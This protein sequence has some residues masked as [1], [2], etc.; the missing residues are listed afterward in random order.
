[1]CERE[2]YSYSQFCWDIYTYEYGE[3]LNKCNLYITLAEKRTKAIVIYVSETFE[4]FFYSND[5]S[6]AS[7]EQM[8]RI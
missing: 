2:S 6:F 3:L 7:Y 4:H 8:C 5:F 1:M